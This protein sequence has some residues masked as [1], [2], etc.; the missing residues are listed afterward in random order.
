MAIEGDKE[1]KEFVTRNKIKEIKTT[2]FKPRKKK[3][4]RL[5]TKFEKKFD[6]RGNLVYHKK[7]LSK[8]GKMWNCETRIYDEEYYLIE[9]QEL[10]NFSKD[11]TKISKL[12]YDDS[13]SQVWI[14]TEEG[15]RNHKWNYSSIKFL[16]EQKQIIAQMMSEKD[17]LFFHYN[18]EGNYLGR[19]TSKTKFT[20]GNKYNANGNLIESNF[21]N[22]T[23]NIYTLDSIGNCI[24]SETWE[25]NQG[26]Y[27][28]ESWKKLKYSNKLISE[29]II[30][31]SENG[32]KERIEYFYKEE[33]LTMKKYFNHKNK[34]EVI[35]K[36][37][38][39]F[40]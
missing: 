3:L 24:K 34:L 33:L 30:Y 37:E 21:F 17:T 14:E 25:S 35:D 32:V 40:Y 1:E 20:K 23:K 6:E 9:R 4:K 13:K 18:D 39:S 19:S 7:Y 5:K 31:D 38:Y 11:Y 27:V 15:P 10:K 26:Q 16:N 28:L 2:V 12:I 22:G 29:L 8:D 36:Y